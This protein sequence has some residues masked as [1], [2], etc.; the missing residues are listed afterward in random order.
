M[1]SQMSNTFSARFGAAPFSELV[2]EIQHQFHADRE[3]MYLAAADFFG[4]N[5]ILPFS[6]F[7]D[8][9]GYAGSLPSVSYLVGLFTD[10]VAAHR[11]YIERYVASLPL[12]I[13]SGDHTFQAC[14]ALNI[15][16]WCLTC[17][18]F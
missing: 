14:F 10:N 5:G 7:D 15:L 13:A 6:A 9:Q 1:M 16:L 4:R 11:I 18:L 8:P 17:I 2:S 12:T 3:L